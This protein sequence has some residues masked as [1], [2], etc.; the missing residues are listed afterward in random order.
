VGLEAVRAFWLVRVCPGDAVE[1]GQ[2]EGDGLG[3]VVVTAGEGSEV[4]PGVGSQG[5][6][7]VGEVLGGAGVVD[8]DV[9][10]ISGELADDDWS[11]AL[12]SS[13]RMLFAKRGKLSRSCRDSET[14]VTMVPRVGGKL[15]VVL[16][17]GQ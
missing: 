3:A 10:V 13:L 8:V 15:K 16:S 6:G 1:V 9:Q 14:L 2:S 4:D 5:L 12:T 17:V 11:M 7:Y